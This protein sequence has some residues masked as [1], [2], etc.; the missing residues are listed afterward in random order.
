VT[1]PVG[2]RFTNPKQGRVHYIVVRSGDMDRARW[3]TEQRDIAADYLSVFGEA[4][5]AGP[6]EIEISVDSND[7]R[8]HSE[9]SIGEIRVV[10]R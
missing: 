2:S 5:A 7:T 6:D 9:S 4:P 8:S 1:A 10:P 3:M